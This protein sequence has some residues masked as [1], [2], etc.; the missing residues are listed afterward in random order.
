MR[1]CAKPAM[2]KGAEA[3]DGA[4]GEWAEAAGDKVKGTI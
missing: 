2:G 4:A 1:K 3:A